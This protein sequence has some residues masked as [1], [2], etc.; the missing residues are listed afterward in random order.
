MSVLLAHH[1][2]PHH[3]PVLLGLFAAGFWLGW[4][5]VSLRRPR[6]HAPR[7]EPDHRDAG[8]APDGPR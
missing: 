3:V 4:H 6:A 8:A 1:L 5:L 2:E 7:P